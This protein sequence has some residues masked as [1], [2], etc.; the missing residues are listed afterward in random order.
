[1]GPPTR[2]QRDWFRQKAYRPPLVIRVVGD[3]WTGGRNN[4]RRVKDFLHHSERWVE[5]QKANK[6]LM[7]NVVPKRK[8]KKRSPEFDPIPY[9]LSTS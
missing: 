8:S 9:T 5:G 4:P 3:G 1:M 6:G 2:P 7:V